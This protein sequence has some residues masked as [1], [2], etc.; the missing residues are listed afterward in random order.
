MKIVFHEDF[1]P[2]YTYDAAAVAGR[3]ESIVDAIRPM[4]DFIEAEA[5]TEAEIR[6]VHTEGQI[7][8]VKHIGLFPIA[9]S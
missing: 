7:E 5:A 3:M 2:E 1:Y 6:A 9:A 4:A 8:R